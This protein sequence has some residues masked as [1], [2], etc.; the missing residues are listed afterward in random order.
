M[1]IGNQGIYADCRACRAVMGTKGIAIAVDFTVTA[2]ATQPQAL[3]CLRL[4]GIQ[5]GI[6][7]MA[8]TA[9]SEGKLVIIGQHGGI[10]F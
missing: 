4:V 9:I 10:A 3:A 1:L 2:G 6:C 8:R 7:A 5:T